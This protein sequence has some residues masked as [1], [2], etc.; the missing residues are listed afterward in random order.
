M[1]ETLPTM[2]MQHRADAKAM[3]HVLA[4]RIRTMLQSPKTGQMETQMM[5]STVSYYNAEHNSGQLL[6]QCISEQ[7][8]QSGQR[9][10]LVRGMDSYA[11]D[12]HQRDRRVVSERAGRTGI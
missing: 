1:P 5:Q 4:A 10:G 8:L 3:I 9:A 7:G 11:K 12:C 6:T 2:T